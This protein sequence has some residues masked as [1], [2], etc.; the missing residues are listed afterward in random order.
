MSDLVSIEKRDEER[1][2]IITVN[3]D[4]R[5]GV[6][7]WEQSVRSYIQFIGS[8]QRYLIYNMSGLKNAGFTNYMRNRATIL[9]QD[10]RDAT[11]RVALVV[12][13]S[14][15]VRHIFELFINVTGRRVQ[16]F[17]TVKMFNDEEKAVAW[18]SE[19]LPK[20]T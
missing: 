15:V 11:G 6:D 18:V 19:I 5:E 7:A 4:S 17:L 1:L 8:S 3:R 20:Q 12:G 14:P 13:F 9:A 10:N 2:W 16:P